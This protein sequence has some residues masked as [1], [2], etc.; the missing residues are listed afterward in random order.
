LNISWTNCPNVTLLLTRDFYL[1]ILLNIYQRPFGSALDFSLI[2]FAVLSWCLI[3][4][5][6]I[7]FRKGYSTLD[8]IFS[9]HSLISLGTKLY[10]T[11]VD[12]SKVLLH[13]SG[14]ILVFDF[15]FSYTQYYYVSLMRVNLQ[16]PLLTILFKYRQ[17]TLHMTFS[18]WKNNSII[19]IQQWRVISLG[20]KLYCTFVDFS[21]VLLHFSGVILVLDKET[22]C[23]LSFLQFI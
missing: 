18:F 4:E 14:V 13:F 3:S 9:L 6:Q 11:F 2:L 20:T 10:C 17:S 12:F 7:G 23:S 15:R 19:C 1:S 22:I 16:L 21:K 5:S 8:N